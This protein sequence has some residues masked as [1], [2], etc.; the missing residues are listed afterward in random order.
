MLYVVDSLRADDGPLMMAGVDAVACPGRAHAAWTRPSVASMFTGALP[1][2]H[3]VTGPGEAIRAELP[4]LAE[5]LQARGHRTGAVVTNGIL[6]PDLGFGRGFEDYVQLRESDAG[7]RHVRSRALH[8]AALDWVRVGGA[9][10]P[11]RPF[12]LYLHS[13]DPHFPYVAEPGAVGGWDWMKRLREGDVADAAGFAPELRAQ[14]R[15]EVVENGVNLRAF[16][17]AIEAAASGPMLIVVTSD[18]GEE[19]HDHGGWTHGKTLHP[20][21]ID[22]P[23]WLVGAGGLAPACDGLERHVDIPRRIARAAGLGEVFGPS[24]LAPGVSVAHNAV[25]PGR[26]AQLVLEDGPRRVMWDG[27]QW[28]GA[29]LR[30][31]DWRPSRVDAALRIRAEALRAEALASADPSGLLPGELELL[32]E[33]GYVEL[34]PGVDTDAA[35][36]P[37]RDVAPPAP[38]R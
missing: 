8:E 17:A 34:T 25:A 2:A 11:A 37:P 1:P 22:V 15:E 20:E 16:L 32:V 30:G 26:G 9:T 7:H 4:T 23:V 21:I 27:R 33:L 24:P 18:H 12:F 3:G 13:T 6:T 19:F 38:V 10:A 5:H 14:Y 36:A 28:T 31:A 35:S 29:R